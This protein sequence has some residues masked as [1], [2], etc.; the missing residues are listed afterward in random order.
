LSIA[1]GIHLNILGL[2]LQELHALHGL[3][4]I[5]VLP[6]HDVGEGGGDWRLANPDLEVFFF[7]RLHHSIVICNTTLARV[8]LFVRPL[9]DLLI[10]C[11]P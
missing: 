1:I 10:S 3:P 4:G 6:L 8:H 2:L 11:V 9:F 5:A 7:L